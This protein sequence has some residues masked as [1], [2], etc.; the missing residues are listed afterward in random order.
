M[1]LST[2]SSSR[3]TPIQ[4]ATMSASRTRR[5]ALANLLSESAPSACSQASPPMPS[6]PRQQAAPSVSHPHLDRTQIHS[7]LPPAGRAVAPRLHGLQRRLNLQGSASHRLWAA[8]AAHLV[9]RQR[10]AEAMLLAS[11]RLLVAAA[12]SVNLQ[13]SGRPQE[14][15]SARPQ[16]WASQP[17]P[18]ALPAL[19]NR[20]SP[21]NLRR[22]VAL[23]SLRS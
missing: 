3:R 20:P 11:L 15:A 12:R 16:H 5:P 21:H 8:V 7:V 10:L 4:T 1:E 18:L 19:V 14:V 17:I 9:N 23:V 2:S 13:V 6:P 22:L